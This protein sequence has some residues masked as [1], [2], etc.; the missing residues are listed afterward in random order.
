MIKTGLLTGVIFVL[1]TLLRIG[2][3]HLIGAYSDEIFKGILLLW[4]L[5]GTIILFAFGIGVSY[6]IARELS[7]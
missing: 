2:F 3:S 4:I 1:L 5:A 6:S 7:K